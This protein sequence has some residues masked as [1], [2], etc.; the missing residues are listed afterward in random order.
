MRSLK[1]Q[2]LKDAQEGEYYKPEKFVRYDAHT[3]RK[4]NWKYCFKC[5]MEVTNDMDHCD[6][7]DVCVSEY[8]HHCVFFS[9]CIGGGNI[10]CFYGSIGMLIF[11]FVLLG[12]FVMIDLS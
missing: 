3:G 4:I 1:K 5:N 8:D 6:D 10:I 11:N 12:I 2:K 7:C 9:K